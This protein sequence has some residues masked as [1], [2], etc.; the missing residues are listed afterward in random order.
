MPPDL[1]VGEDVARI[2]LPAVL[3]DLLAVDARRTAPRLQVQADAGQIGELVRA[4][5]TFD[6]LPDMDR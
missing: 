5:G 4:P 2:H 1:F 3:V 6:V